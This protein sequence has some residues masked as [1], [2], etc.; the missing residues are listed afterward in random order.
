YSLLRRDIEAEI[1][2]FCQE[3]NIAVIAYS[4]MASGLLTGAMTPERAASLPQDDWRRNDPRFQEPQLSQ[5][6]RLVDVLREIGARHGRTP[7]EVAI[8]WTLRH[9]AVTGAIV[10]AR[11]PDQ[12]EGIVGAADFRLNEEELANIDSFL[13]SQS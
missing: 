3:H 10:G 9:P 6:L 2:P 8:A 11:R 7:G 12:V 5:T 1:L 4:P 13:T